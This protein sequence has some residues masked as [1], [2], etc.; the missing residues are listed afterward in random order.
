M[1]R[2][3]PG[4]MLGCSACREARNGSGSGE[5]S[6]GV[7]PAAAGLPRRCTRKAFARVCSHTR[8]FA[9]GAA[10]GPVRFLPEAKPHVVPAPVRVQ[11]SY[12]KKRSP[13]ARSVHPGTFC[14]YRLI[15]CCRADRDA[16]GG[17]NGPPRSARRR[18]TASRR[19][20]GRNGPA[21]C[22]APR[23]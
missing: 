13:G 6:G 20:P 9:F 17:R 3:R 5:R 23:P 16:A 2:K 8:R 14:R 18:R 15:S 21:S 22:T 7:S 10:T 1:R 11:V 19:V 12:N 4:G